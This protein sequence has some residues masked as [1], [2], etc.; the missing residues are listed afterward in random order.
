MCM[1]LWNTPFRGKLKIKKYE[2][3]ITTTLNRPAEM[4]IDCVFYGRPAQLCD[5]GLSKS[6]AQLRSITREI[7][8]FYLL[9]ASLVAGIDRHLLNYYQINKSKHLSTLYFVVKF[10]Y[11][12]IMLTLNKKV[13]ITL[14]FLLVPFVL[15]MSLPPESGSHNEMHNL[16]YGRC[17][18]KDKPG[19][20]YVGI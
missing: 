4:L 5:A 8:D 20:V 15:L 7:S 19:A 12:K 18:G 16:V 11:Q 1:S 13:S 10:T 14:L 9:I 3:R 2:L 6:S 17:Y